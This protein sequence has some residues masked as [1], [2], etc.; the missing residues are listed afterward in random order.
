MLFCN[1]TSKFHPAGDEARVFAVKIG[2]AEGSTK[3]S[4]EIVRVYLFTR[5]LRGMSFYQITMRYVYSYAFKP[6]SV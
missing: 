1:F 4:G 5:L 3:A 2:D 6:L